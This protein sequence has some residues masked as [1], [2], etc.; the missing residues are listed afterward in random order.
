MDALNV[1]TLVSYGI[2][3][4]AWSA[5]EY[6]PP[7]YSTELT[8]AVADL[9]LQH[10][11]YSYSR[12]NSWQAV[13]DILCLLNDEAKVVRA[14]RNW[15]AE[16]LFSEPIETFIRYVEKLETYQDIPAVWAANILQEPSQSKDLM[17]RLENIFTQRL[18]EKT[19]RVRELLEV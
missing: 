19:A 18:L 9:H 10:T 16:D 3:S 12:I 13:I 8:L 7:D 5:P 4:T 2:R 11:H 15:L 1:Q 17:R 14:L 6:T